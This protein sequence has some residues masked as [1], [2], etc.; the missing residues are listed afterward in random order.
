[1]L[2]PMGS[3]PK[4]SVD[5]IFVYILALYHEQSVVVYTP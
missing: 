1:M 4:G 5:V 2:D 3:I